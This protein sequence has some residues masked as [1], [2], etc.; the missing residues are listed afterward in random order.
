MKT[1]QVRSPV[2]AG[3]FYPND[4]AELAGTVDR[5]LAEARRATAQPRPWALIVPHAGY[6]YSGPIAATGYALLGPAPRVVVLGPAHFV[7]LH[8]LA[9]P[10]ADAW[11]TPLGEVP[12]DEELRDLAVGLGARVDDDPH[13]SEHALEVQLP[14]LQ[15]K[16]GM[17]LRVLPVAVGATEPRAV[18]DLIEALGDGPDR[19]IVVSTDLS[20]YYD[21]ETARK[22][23]R[24]TAD[25]VIARDPRAIRI[26][27]ACGVFA[28]RGIVEHARRRDLA[29]QLLDLRNSSDTAGHT[30]R[31]VGYGAFALS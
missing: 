14:F 31:V 11:A 4:S 17:G 27:D 24:R 30:W 28:L 2:A 16:L 22:L 20:H 3:T 5:L 25:A 7:P 1:Y 18:A 15:R 12:I 8:G 10:A 6:R 13:E 21:A 29:V 26:E 23:D 19:L 9:V